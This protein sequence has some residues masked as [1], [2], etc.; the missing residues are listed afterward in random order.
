MKLACLALLFAVTVA[1]YPGAVPTFHCVGLYWSPPGGSTNKNVLVQFR[2]AGDSA[3]NEGLPMRY[4]P[5]PNTEQDLADY[6]GSI[7]NLTSATAYEIELKLA[8]NSAKTNLTAKTWSETF[9]LGDIVVVSNRDT[10]QEIKQSGTAENWRV[11]DG[12]GAIIDVRHLHDACI[13]VNASYVIIRNF[14]LKGEA[15]PIFHPRELSARSASMAAMT[16]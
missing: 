7:V 12:K 6:R 11:Y 3:W 10:P 8:D 13:N 2:R 16:S 4:N 5:I 1:A 9:P 14:I 15:T